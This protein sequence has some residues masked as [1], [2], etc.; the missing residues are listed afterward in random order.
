MPPNTGVPTA[1]RVM[2]PAPIGRHEQTTE[3]RR[4]VGRR[5]ALQRLQHVLEAAGAR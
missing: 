4:E 3:R 5:L 2:A 1:W